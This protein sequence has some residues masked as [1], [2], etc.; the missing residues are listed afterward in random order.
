MSGVQPIVHAGHLEFIVE[1]RHRPQPAHDHAARRPPGRNAISSPSN[2]CTS[3]ARAGAL[4]HRLPSRRCTS[5][6]RSASGNS[7][8]LPAFIAT[9]T[10][11]RSSRR[12][13]RPMT[14]RWPLVTGSNVPGYRP[15]ALAGPGPAP[16][17]VRHPRP[18]PRAAA[19]RPRL[20]RRRRR[21]PPPGT[22]W[23]PARPGPAGTASRPWRSGR[24]AAPGRPA[25][26]SAGPASVTSITSS[27]GRT[28]KRAGH[29]R[30]GARASA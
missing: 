23:S 19:G 12:A 24:S 27:P 7:G 25:R 8:A 2:G 26:G 6:T 13:A 1:I 16:R 18:L 21:P 17:A 3:I 4:D 22:R 15:D 30:P 9:P 11:S 14:S 5:S 20:G 28:G 29:R 10:T